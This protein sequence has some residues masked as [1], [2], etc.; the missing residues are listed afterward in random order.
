MQ[1]P[2]LSII[3]CL[4]AYQPELGRVPLRASEELGR[5]ILP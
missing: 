3:Y 5:M 2:L 1:T 4:A